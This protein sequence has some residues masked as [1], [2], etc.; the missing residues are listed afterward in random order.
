M[1]TTYHRIEELYYFLFHD[2]HLKNYVEIM[3]IC[4]KQEV[5]QTVE[6][7]GIIYM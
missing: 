7:Q 2:C 4:N 1:S 5:S 6:V 3:Y